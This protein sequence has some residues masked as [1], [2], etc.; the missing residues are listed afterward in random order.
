LARAAADCHAVRA[1]NGGGADGAGAVIALDLGVQPVAEADRADADEADLATDG[2][3]ATIRASLTDLCA[4]VGAGTR[5]DLDTANRLGLSRHG[6]SRDSRGKYILE[7][8]AISP[9]NPV[10]TRNNAACGRARMASKSLPIRKHG[11]W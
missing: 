4:P 1:A 10:I 8:H 11:Q 3:P 6:Q 7:I 9:Q 2:E 5:T